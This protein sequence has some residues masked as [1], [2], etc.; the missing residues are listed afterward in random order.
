MD[1][2][3]PPPIITFRARPVWRSARMGR[4]LL[5][6]PRPNLTFDVIFTRSG[7]RMHCC[8]L[9]RFA[10]LI[11]ACRR[12]PATHR[13]GGVSLAPALIISVVVSVLAACDRATGP[14]EFAPTVAASVSGAIVDVFEVTLPVPSDTTAAIGNAYVQPTATPGSVNVLAFRPRGAANDILAIGI[15]NVRAPGEMQS[16]GDYHLHGSPGRTFALQTRVRV[17]RLTSN[18]LTGVFT[19]IGIDPQPP[20]KTSPDTIIIANGRFDLP[21]NAPIPEP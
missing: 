11:V 8:A 18:R 14:A 15:P 9:G 21:L 19:A 1:A 6:L 16:G 10:S 7:T 12:G 5:A 13:I 3:H 17:T 2:N 20:G 4:K